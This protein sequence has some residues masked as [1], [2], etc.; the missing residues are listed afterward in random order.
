MNINILRENFLE[1]LSFN[2]KTQTSKVSIPILL[3]VCIEAKE[4]KLI[5]KS[6]NLENSV[7]SISGVEIIKEG[8]TTVNLKN[9]YE[10]I[11]NL[12]S[13]VIN[14][15]FEEGLLIISDDKNKISLNTIPSEEFPNIPD[16]EGDLIFKIPAYDFSIGLDKV[17]F[18]T[19]NDL[20]K[21]VLSGIL[22]EFNKDKLKLI[23]IN[24]FRYSG[25]EVSGLKLEKNKN[26]E[27]IIVPSQALDSVSKIINE[28]NL[29]N[30]FLISVYIFGKNNQLIFEMG[31]VKFVI[32]LIEGK[33]P[34]YTKIFP[35]EYECEFDISTEEFRDIVKLSNVFRFK[36]LSRIYFEIDSKGNMIKCSSSLKEVGESF[37]IIKTKISGID[38]KVSFNSKYLMDFLNHV[39]EDT[40]HISIN[41]SSLKK[42][43][44]FE[45]KGNKDYTYLVMPLLER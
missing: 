37:S 39:N 25:Y 1:L 2:V 12:K 28:L 23:G 41:S 20:S 42:V 29:D 30:D 38:S 22:F 6:T 27:N 7:I 43:S 32:R 18:S 26:L 36:D 10:F 45:E 21:L 16:K 13:D 40:L 24:G 14:I 33:Y 31:S 35:S 4:G 15:K 44:K 8:S 34:D 17:T 3:N 5:L 11:S 9:L 19:S